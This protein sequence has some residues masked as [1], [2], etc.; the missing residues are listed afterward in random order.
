MQ[1]LLSVNNNGNDNDDEKRK[2]PSEV[3][4]EILELL[5]DGNYLKPV[6]W[7]HHK[8]DS[9]C[10]GVSLGVRPFV[11][12][13]FLYMKLTCLSAAV[14][15]AD[16]DAQLKDV[17]ALR[18]VDRHAEN[19]D[20]GA[21]SEYQKPV[22]ACATCQFFFEE[23]LEEEQ[24]NFPFIGNCAEY[25]VIRTKSRNK[26]TEIQRSS[27]WQTSKE[28]CKEYFEKRNGL[29]SQLQNTN[30]SGISD[31]QKN[32][33]ETYFHDINA[34]KKK[35]LLNKNCMEK[36]KKIE[37]FGIDISHDVCKLLLFNEYFE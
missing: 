7:A 11:R 4:L 35:A 8:N 15:N 21:S 2:K 19:Y 32:L 6:V 33:L 28:T 27:D 36:K 26:I 18:C 10:F 5:P 24:S 34:K 12:P 23:Q 14:E 13:V 1:D 9:E 22:K 31:Q 17:V 20:A 3:G 16:N 37:P 29:L 25:D 30:E